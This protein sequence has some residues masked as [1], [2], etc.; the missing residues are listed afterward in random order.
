MSFPIEVANQPV[1]CGQDGHAEDGLKEG[2]HPQKS[3][4]KTSDL[5]SAID[6]F[7][8]PL[9]NGSSRRFQPRDALPR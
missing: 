9:R 7:H 6:C 2:D 8:Q 1:A 3:N 4:C 5:H